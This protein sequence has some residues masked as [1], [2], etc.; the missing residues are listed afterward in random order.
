MFFRN[1][2]DTSLESHQA[3]SGCHS[4][5]YQYT[6]N[7]TSMWIIIIIPVHLKENCTMKK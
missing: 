4:R 3:R 5:S 1:N 7:E 2:K 6:K